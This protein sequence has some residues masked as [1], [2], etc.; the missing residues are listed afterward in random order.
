LEYPPHDG[1]PFS[2]N[3]S[4][5]EDIGADRVIELLREHLG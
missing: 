1:S 2:G 3:T 5:K 4:V